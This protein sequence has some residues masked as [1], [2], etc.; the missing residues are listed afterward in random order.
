MS[1]M[2]TFDWPSVKDGLAFSVEVMP[3]SLAVSIT[4]SVPIAI[5]KRTKPVFDDTAKARVMERVP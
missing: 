3:I 1:S 2:V 4:F 5:C